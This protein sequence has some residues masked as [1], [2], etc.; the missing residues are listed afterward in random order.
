MI[1]S[2]TR[3]NIMTLLR[4]YRYGMRAY[5]QERLYKNKRGLAKINKN[6]DAAEGEEER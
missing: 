3:G 4:R 1:F 6:K 5:W 2:F